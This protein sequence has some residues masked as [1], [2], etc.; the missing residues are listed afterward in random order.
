[1]A[2][3]ELTDNEKAFINA[4]M[5]YK[6]SVINAAESIGIDK[7]TGYQWARRLKEDIIEAAR[8]I[9]AFNAHKAVFTFTDALEDGAPVHRD[10][11]EAAKQILD[12]IGIVK[13]E[14]VEVKTDLPGIILLPS[15]RDNET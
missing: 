6:G 8:D 13:E 14:K 7:S 15:K 5:E 11:L 9:L 12:R 10:K 4:L 2:K 1:M 3:R